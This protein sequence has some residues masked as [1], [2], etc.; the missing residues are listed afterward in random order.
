[1]ETI[2]PDAVIFDVDG[3]IVNG[4]CTRLFIDHLYNK[5]R[6]SEEDIW[7]YTL[8]LKKHDPNNLEYSDI[9]LEAFTILSRIDQDVL[10][11]E[12]AICAKESIIP[13]FNKQ[14]LDILKNY[15]SQLK[16]IFLAS[17]SPD[18]LIKE[19]A[20]ELNISLENLIASTIT[21]HNNSTAHQ[22][23]YFLCIG[24]YK[25][26]AIVDLFEKKRMNLENAVFY[27]DNVSDIPLL[28]KVGSGYWAGSS[29]VFKD[30]NL[31]ISGV[32]EVLTVRS[33]NKKSYFLDDKLK[34]YFK[35]KKELIDRSIKNV[36][37]AICDESVLNDFTGIVYPNWD[38]STM[39]T[40][41]FDPINE[42]LK[43]NDKKLL[44]LGTCIFLEAAGLD[45]GKYQNLISIGDLLN[46]SNE[47]FVDITNWTS[48]EN[49]STT[50][51]SHLEISVIGNASISLLSLPVHK[52]IHNEP[53]L[54]AEIK[55]KIYE[56]YTGIVFR[57][58]FANGIK[59]YWEQQDRISASIA[60]YFEISTLLNS[61]L[62]QFSVDLFLI[63]GN[64][65][66][67][68]IFKN[69][70]SNSATLIQLQRDHMAFS[71]WKN[72]D[73]TSG[74]NRFNSNSNLICIHA[75][76]QNNDPYLFKDNKSV[77]DTI[78]LCQD[79]RSIQFLKHQINE[80]QKKVSLDIE[81]MPFDQEYRSLIDSYVNQLPYM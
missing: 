1:M 21:F 45:T 22:N 16:D 28:K 46:L 49:G 38:I 50:N 29:E 63:L 8:L 68:V 41:F 35:E 4:N 57:S 26:K 75:S 55:M 69:F 61:G 48:N 78:S 58:L 30:K 53:L 80:Y 31:K 56:S 44:S 60:D 64:D 36:F 32:T 42:Y 7:N 23:D 20:K 77:K 12:T 11:K 62:I 19:I 67:S 51:K 6:L 54:D 39:Q 59:L 76:I 73:L 9:A 40:A 14:I 65:R 24:R 43:N 10:K 37:P 25:E 34:K 2:K 74:K 70:I 27:T 81:R 18:F 71:C 13:K 66:A 15:Q 3:T 47:A 72:G 17:G 52:I 33:S 79:S 5:N